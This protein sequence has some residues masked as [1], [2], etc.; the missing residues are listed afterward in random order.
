MHRDDVVRCLMD[1][2]PLLLGYARAIVRNLHSAEDIFQEVMI[3]ALEHAP[4]LNDHGHVSAWA[5]KTSGFLALNEI[6]RRH[7]KDVSLDAM[8]GLDVQ[9][10]LEPAWREAAEED[11]KARLDALQRCLGRLSP[12]A[13]SLITL[14]FAEGLDCPQVAARLGKPLNTVYVGLSRVYRKLAECIQGRPD[15]PEAAS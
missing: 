8:L 7:R 10:L 6:R 12:A 3:L 11:G 9:E 14:R 2:R 4:E 13:R 5:R 15:S 1:Q